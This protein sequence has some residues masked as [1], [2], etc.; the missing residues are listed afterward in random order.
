MRFGLLVNTGSNLGPTAE[1]VFDFTRA[2]AERAE[3]LGYDDL[4][5]TEHHFIRFGISPSAL[6][7]AAFILG[8]T[9]RLNVETAVTLSPLLHPVEMAERA[10]LLD[11]LSGGRFTLGLGRGGY[12]KDFEVLDKD[13][14]RWDHDPQ[15]AAA[16]ILNAWD[17]AGDKDFELQPPVH[18]LPHPPLML[19]TTS[20]DGV[21]F[22]AA[23]GLALQHYFA[24]PA[25]PRIAVEERYAAE[26]A[27][28][29]V[30]G[31]AP[32][33]LHCLIAI[34][35]EDPT[36]R[37]GL[38]RALQQSFEAGEHPHVPNAG[39]H[40][41]PDGEPVG[42]AAQAAMSAQGAIIGSAAQVVDELGTFVERT[43]AARIAIHPE[44][45][46]DRDLTLQTVEAFAEHVIP[47][48]RV[49]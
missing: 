42:P 24:M 38:Q 23:H 12:A 33:H 31:P 25:E 46:A 4:W 34:V 19:G 39:S 3:D 7:M 16:G 30:Q 40:V 11:Q 5:V 22:A 27:A 47:Q 35:S 8:R 49:D 14:A 10:A 32:E 45:S 41:G 37:D 13:V 17:P 48:L 28:A 15:A 1:D 44:A 29:G 43:G 18:T 21:R 36:A 2:Q 26:R 9:R 20:Q 6:T